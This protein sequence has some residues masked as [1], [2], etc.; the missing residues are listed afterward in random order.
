M[1]LGF[2]RHREQHV[3]MQSIVKLYGI[4]EIIN[5]SL[6]ESSTMHVSG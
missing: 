3:Q 5:N 1:V 6:A 2:S 4:K